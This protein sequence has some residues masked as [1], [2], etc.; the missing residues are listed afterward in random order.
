[1]RSHGEVY[2]VRDLRALGVLRRGWDFSKRKSYVHL[3]V[4]DMHYKM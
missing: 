1:M 3:C 4:G 2:Q